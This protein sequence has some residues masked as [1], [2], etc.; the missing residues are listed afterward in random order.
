VAA[1]AAARRWQQRAQP[2]RLDAPRT[3]AVPYAEHVSRLP[4]TLRYAEFPGEHEIRLAELQAVMQWLEEI[5]GQVCCWS[6]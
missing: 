5:R 6:T 2:V 1:G 4:L 3:A